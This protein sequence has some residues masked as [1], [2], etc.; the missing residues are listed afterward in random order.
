MVDLMY[1]EQIHQKQ[2]GRPFILTV[3]PKGWEKP[4]RLRLLLS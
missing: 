3:Q 1:F 2:I 4:I